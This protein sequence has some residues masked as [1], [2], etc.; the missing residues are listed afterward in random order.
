VHLA[1]HALVSPHLAMRCFRFPADPPFRDRGTRKTADPAAR[2]CSRC[3][4]ESK[5]VSQEKFARQPLTSS[6]RRHCVV[7]KRTVNSL[8]LAS[9][10]RPSPR[11]RGLSP[12]LGRRVATIANFRVVAVIAKDPASA[13]SAPPNAAG[14]VPATGALSSDYCEF[15]GGSGYSERS[16]LRSIGYPQRCGDCPRDGGAE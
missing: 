16:G 14:I 15:S 12:R 2:R 13:L 3:P 5:P 4:G 10:A 7:F 6:L 11:L 8:N 1:V 9:P